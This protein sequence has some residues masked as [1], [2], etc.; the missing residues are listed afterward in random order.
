MSFFF[1]GSVFAAHEREPYES[2]N[3]DAEPAT[4]ETKNRLFSSLVS[5][6]TFVRNGEKVPL[7]VLESLTTNRHLYAVLLHN[8][9][10]LL[11]SSRS[12][13]DSGCINEQVGIALKK[14]P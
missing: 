1:L 6:P 13:S 7:E 10:S 12:I 3:V 9:P 2:A 14:I 11:I 4:R 5:L 8:Y